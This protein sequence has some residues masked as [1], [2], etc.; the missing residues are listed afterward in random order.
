MSKYT[1]TLMIL[2]TILTT[3][4]FISCNKD[5]I[6]T[7][8]FVGVWK[9]QK[10][11]NMTGGAYDPE[12]YGYFHYLKIMSNGTY[13]SL[14]G[15]GENDY[16]MASGTCWTENEQRIDGKTRRFYL[17]QELCQT[18]TYTSRYEQTLSF[19]VIEK[20]KNQIIL[21]PTKEFTYYYYIKTNDNTFNQ[22]YET[23]KKVISSNYTY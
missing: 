6:E 1:Y 9:L 20:D 12:Q 13:V 16:E 23:I 19:E 7:E 14:E 15:N 21:R 5:D 3:Q 11:S 17:K 2:V 8:D 18:K 4:L 22:I 10:I